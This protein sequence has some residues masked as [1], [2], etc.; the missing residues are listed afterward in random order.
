MIRIEFDNLRFLIV[1]DNPHMRRILRALLQGFGSR[2]IHEAADGK[3]GIEAFTKYTPDIVIMDWAMP[4]F[5]GLEFAR[6]IRQPESNASPFTPIIM[7]TGHSER[8]R[9]TAARDAGVTEFMVKPISANGLH[10]RIL[11]IVANPRRFI[12]TKTYFG[13]D[14]RRN[15]MP[16]YTGPERRK[17][18]KV[19]LD[20]LHRSRAEN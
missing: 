16:G 13:P 20:R 17:G 2:E 9:V 14:R 8:A 11:N 5:D 4:I 1:E 7:L 12:K 10:R 18:G 19:D 6:M 3:A 15:S